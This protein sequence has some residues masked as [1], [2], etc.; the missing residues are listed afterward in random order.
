MNDLHVHVCQC[1]VKATK[2]YKKTCTIG[3]K[4]TIS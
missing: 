1:D 2:S 3:W 4:C